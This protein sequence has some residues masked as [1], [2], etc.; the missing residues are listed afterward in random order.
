M[1]RYHLRPLAKKGLDSGEG[2]GRIRGGSAA[3]LL[4][5]GQGS[6]STNL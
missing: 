5:Q 1:L 2:E 4:R 6:T 3:R